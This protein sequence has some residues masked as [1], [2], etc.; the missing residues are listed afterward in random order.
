MTI[1]IYTNNEKPAKILFD[2]KKPIYYHKNEWQHKHGQYI[3]K[4]ELKKEF[5]W[6]ITLSAKKII[7]SYMYWFYIH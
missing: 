1:Q 7:T 3:S 6:T 4:V 5:F 2:L